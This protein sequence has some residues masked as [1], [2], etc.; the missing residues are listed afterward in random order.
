M[1][2]GFSNTIREGHPHYSQYFHQWKLN[3]RL[4][5]RADWRWSK[6]TGSNINCLM[7]FI[8]NTFHKFISLFISL[9]KML[10]KLLIFLNLHDRCIFIFTICPNQRKWFFFFAIFTHHAI[11]LV[12]IYF[13]VFVIVFVNHC[14]SV[15]WS[16]Y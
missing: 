2:Q 8:L 15:L 9:R 5:S 1:N 10:A 4:I 6:G 3:L 7:A 11:V 13:S 14:C 16:I 12:F